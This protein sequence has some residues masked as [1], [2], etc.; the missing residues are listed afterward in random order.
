MS[1]SKRKGE[2]LGIP[3]GT[4]TAWLRKLILFSLLKKHNENFCFRCKEE[5]E[6]ADELT[7]DHIEPWE[8]ID[9]NLFWNLEN[10]TFSHRKC[11]RPH[12]L[13]GGGSKKKHSPPEE[14]AWCAEHKSFLPRSLFD[15]GGRWDGLKDYCKECRRSRRKRN[16]GR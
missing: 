1:S 8:G 9:V 14:M 11:N 3:H 13:K 4:A 15:Q 5:I 6:S 16:L 12:R 10:I 2:F 7:I